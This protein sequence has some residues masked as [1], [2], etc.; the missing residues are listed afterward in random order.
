[1]QQSSGIFGTCVVDKA[2]V[3]AQFEAWSQAWAQ[4]YLGPPLLI[5]GSCITIIGRDLPFARWDCAMFA[6]CP[7]CWLYIVA[8]FAFK[9]RWCGTFL[10]SF[11]YLL[12]ICLVGAFGF[13]W[14]DGGR[15]EADEVPTFDNFI[16]ALISN[17]FLIISLT[18]WPLI[19]M[20]RFLLIYA[21]MA[22]YLLI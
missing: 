10:A 19:L 8:L 22:V 3:W 13:A 9:M 14:S 12:L 11:V 4:F 6:R 7:N 21:L 17:N 15:F 1:M 5:G 20:R 2:S 16:K 18:F